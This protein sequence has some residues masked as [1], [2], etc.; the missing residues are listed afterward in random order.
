M[1]IHNEHLTIDEYMRFVKSLGVAHRIERN[2]I[3]LY[4]RII[5]KWNKPLDWMESIEKR[6]LYGGI[7]SNA[8]WYIWSLY[9]NEKLP[10]DFIKNESTT[11][12]QEILKL[13]ITNYFKLETIILD[14]KS[15]YNNVFTARFFATVLKVS[16]F[17]GV[18]NIE[19]IKFDDLSNA[20]VKEILVKEQFYFMEI[21]RQKLGYSQGKRIVNEP[22]KK[23][24]REE[25][26]IIKKSCWSSEM[27]SLIDQFLDDMEGSRI[28]LKMRKEKKAH[29]NLFG[30]WLLN[31]NRNSLIEDLKCLDRDMWLKYVST[32]IKINE[33]AE[34]S[35]NAR[36]TTVIQFFDWLKVKKGYI[37]SNDFVYYNADFKILNTSNNQYDLAF[38]KREYG[39]KILYYL[40]NEYKP[41]S[42]VEKKIIID[43]FCREAIIICANSGMRIS[44]IFNMEYKSVFFSNDENN[45]KMIIK[46]ADKLG[47]VNRPVYF[48]KDGYEAIKRLE[49]LRRKSGNLKERYNK[50]TK[51]SFI[52]LFEVEE[53]KLLNKNYIYEFHNKVK[54]I[55]KL[56]DDT[57]R[58]VKGQMHAYRH[59]FGMT[60]FRLSNYNISVVR[61]LLGHR[62]Y[63]MSERYLV[64]ENSILF[65][66]IREENEAKKIAGKGIDTFYNLIVKSINKQGRYSKLEK[67][68]SSNEYLA[69][70]IDEKKIKKVSLGYCLKPCGKENK[71][72]KCNNFL[73]TEKE[74]NELFIFLKDL[75]GIVGWKIGNINI[76]LEE[77]MRIPS[78]S[79]DIEDITILI[80]E[81]KNLGVTDD[82]LNDELNCKKE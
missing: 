64:E 15:K 56:V 19:N 80:K 74:K 10:I 3:N 31:I 30:A 13:Y 78:I 43:E 40:I 75:I 59:F 66:K 1:V 5:N 12:S 37:I 27:K 21:L 22:L 72:F 51:T 45:Y 23:I 6:V 11:K 28:N 36:L 39:E 2:Y 69:N 29:I 9:N 81:L 14:L 50:R 41:I 63:K 35:R 60:V 44:E 61:Y 65:S 47:Q 71:C 8:Y 32:V 55:L 46:Y 79:S 42:S 16:A 26:K 62:S 34:K 48:T 17:L 33:L 68:I 73:V 82:E 77:A 20:F 49:D 67:Y 57:G 52:H 18:N 76:S 53:G 70:I 4:K 7:T 58:C 38:E 24:L 54:Y 25:R